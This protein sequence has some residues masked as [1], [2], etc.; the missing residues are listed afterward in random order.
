[1]IPAS[2]YEATHESSWTEI[3]VLPTLWDLGGINIQD[4]PGEDGRPGVPEIEIRVAPKLLQLYAGSPQNSPHVKQF[5]L[6]KEPQFRSGSRKSGALCN[7]D[8]CANRHQ[9]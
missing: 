6:N 8:L 3:W 9:V 7:R 4:V 1:M 5:L 2:R